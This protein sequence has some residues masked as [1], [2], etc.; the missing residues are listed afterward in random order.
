ML[1]IV[2]RCALRAGSEVYAEE[3][4][5]FGLTT[6]ARRHAVVQGKTVRFSF[7]A[8][9]G[10]RAIVELVDS[11]SR[12]GGESAPPARGSRLFALDGADHQRG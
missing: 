8:K 11:S 3:N 1:R 5:S 9:S 6:L 4:D 12:A 7:P 10:Q 2:D